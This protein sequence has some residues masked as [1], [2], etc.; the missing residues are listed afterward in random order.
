[1]NLKRNVHLV[2]SSRSRYIRHR[3][4]LYLSKETYINQKRPTKETPINQKRP[5][6]IKRDRNQSTETHINSTRPRK[7]TCINQKRPVSIKRDQQKRSVSIKGDQQKRPISIKRDLYQSKRDLYQS[8]RSTKETHINEERDACK[9][10]SY[11]IKET[12][13]IQKRPIS[14]KRETQNDIR[15]SKKTYKGDLLTKLGNF[16]SQVRRVKCQTE[17]SCVCHD[18]FVC[19]P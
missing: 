1:M 8:K 2:N 18:S 15:Q 17:T 10:D 16:F 5:V 9:R 11:K 19:V 14:I 12:Y 6:S 7:E 4:D 13:K 3:N